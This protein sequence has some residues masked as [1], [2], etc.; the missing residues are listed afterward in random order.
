MKFDVRVVPENSEYVV[1]VEARN[2][3]IPRAWDTYQSHEDAA[4]VAFK[5]GLLIDFVTS[6]SAE[7]RCA[8]CEYWSNPTKRHFEHKQWGKTWGVCGSDD[9]EDGRDPPITGEKFYCAAWRERTA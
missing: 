1:E 6:R 2:G 3:E 5:L 9:Y 4:K 7:A 8:T